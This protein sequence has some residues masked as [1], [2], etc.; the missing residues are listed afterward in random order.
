MAE[1]WPSFLLIE[2]AII[3]NLA[4][5]F[6]AL[7]WHFKGLAVVPHHTRDVCN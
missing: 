5:G 7:F 1:I 6:I 3:D 4:Q 2:Q